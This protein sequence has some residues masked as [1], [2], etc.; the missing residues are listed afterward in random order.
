M[1]TGDIL[2]HD[3]G[4]TFDGYFADFGRNYGLDPA[5][6]TAQRTYDVF[7]RATEAGIS[8]VRLQSYP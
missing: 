5:N 4:A 2:M 8:A 7:Y 1:Q 6:E 3:S